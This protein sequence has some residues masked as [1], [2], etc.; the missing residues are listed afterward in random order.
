MF[1][2]GPTPTR[3]TSRRHAGRT[4]LLLTGALA[5]LPGVASAGQE[6]IGAERCGTCHVAEYEDWKKSG[7]AEALARLSQSQQ[8]DPVCRSCHTT[9]AR[10]DDPALSGVQCESCHGAGS[11]YAP[12]HVMRDPALAELLGLEKV[13]ATTCAPCHTASSP[14]VRPFD[15]AAAVQKI[16]H[17]KTK[18]VSAA[19][20]E[21]PKAAPANP[22]EA[23]VPV[24]RTVS[25]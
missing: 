18:K 23:G 14:K 25:P 2:A 9:G 3:T 19:P 20:A 17:G 1:P 6:L 11:L 21:A 22:T 15:Y 16:A 13:S 10:K 12:A 7:H 4:T 5:L 24:Q 8:Q